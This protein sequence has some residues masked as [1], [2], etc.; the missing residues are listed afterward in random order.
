MVRIIERNPPQ[1][2]PKLALFEPIK[3]VKMRVFYLS[4]PE[5]QFRLLDRV[6]CNHI[7]HKPHKTSNYWKHKTFKF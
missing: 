4:K 1:I 2:E 6:H 7:C 5:V 3:T